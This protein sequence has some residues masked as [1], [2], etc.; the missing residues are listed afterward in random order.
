MPGYK[1]KQGIDAI[2]LICLSQVRYNL[3]LITS[4]RTAQFCTPLLCGQTEL[5]SRLFGHILVQF[6]IPVHRLYSIR[7]PEFLDWVKDDLVQFTVLG[8]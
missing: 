1:P 5:Y 2:W 7:S 6:V 4:N 8:D 3:F